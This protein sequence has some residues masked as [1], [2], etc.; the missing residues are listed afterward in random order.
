MKNLHEKE[1][2]NR[3]VMH[4]SIREYKEKQKLDISTI[5]ENILE[6]KKTESSTLKEIS[7]KN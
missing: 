7:K 6:M 3:S 4:T 5:K 1:N 2:V